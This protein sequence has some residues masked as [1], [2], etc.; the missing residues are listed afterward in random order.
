MALMKLNFIANVS[1]LYDY[2]YNMLYI[3]KLGV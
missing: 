2:L 1:E 3:I